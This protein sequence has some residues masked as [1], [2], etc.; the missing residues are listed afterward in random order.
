[1][2]IVATDY[3]SFGNLQTYLQDVCPYVKMEQIQDYWEL[4]ALGFVDFPICVAKMDMTETEYERMIDDLRQLEVDAFN[5]PDGKMPEEDDPYY[6]RYCK[7]GW[8]WDF[9][10]NADV[11][12]VPSKKQLIRKKGDQR[13]DMRKLLIVIDMQKDFID[14]ALGTPEAEAIVENVKNKICA[15]PP[16]D[17]IFTMD[18]HGEDYMET[19]EGKNLP[20]PHCIRGTEGWRLHPEI[21]ALAGRPAM[22]YEKPTFGSMELANDLRILSEKEEIELEIVGLC[23]DICVV[24]NALLLKA[25]MPE[26]SISVDAACCAG[27]T[28]ESHLAALTTM[29][30]CQ[31][32]VTEG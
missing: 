10:F 31:I 3:I 15:F 28:P 21:A 13:T 14:G 23:T 6:V 2:Y 11:W 9:F 7:Y 29:R 32:N 12:E 25:A 20:V 17:V 24:S 30:F 19:Q 16:E 1:M 5:T 27:V 8:L 22:I 26:V 4:K 18:T